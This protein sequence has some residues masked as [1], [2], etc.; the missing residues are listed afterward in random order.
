MCVY[1]CVINS[2]IWWHTGVNSGLYRKMFKKGVSQQA[3]NYIEGSA[4]AIIM[5]FAF[6]GE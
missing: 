4:S 3:N 1:V 5:M 2:D 6:A